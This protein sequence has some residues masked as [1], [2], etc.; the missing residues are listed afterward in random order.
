MADGKVNRMTIRTAEAYFDAN[1]GGNNITV[2]VTA[3]TVS[4][5]VCIGATGYFVFLNDYGQTCDVIPAGNTGNVYHFSVW[6]SGSGINHRI[7]VYFLY[8]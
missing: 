4:G 5:K 3:P 2:D 1:S 6:V 8:E 7:R